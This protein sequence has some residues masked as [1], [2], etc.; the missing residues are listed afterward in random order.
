MNA[1]R[2]SAYLV[3]V[4]CLTLASRVEGQNING[5]ISGTVTDSSG[6]VVPNAN[7]TLRS[8]ITEAVANVGSNSSGLYHFG[9][10]QRGVYNLEV[11]ARG[12]QTYVQKGIVLNINDRVTVNATLR[13]G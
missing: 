8:T 5:S 13:V 10:L 9:N 2:R 6:A 11:A 4:L 3:L 1:T 7:C 12:F